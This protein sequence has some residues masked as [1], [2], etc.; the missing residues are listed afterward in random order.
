[1]DILM[2]GHSGSGKTTFMAGLYSRMKNGAAGFTIDS[3]YSE[4]RRNTSNY[5]YDNFLQQERDLDKIAENLHRG[6]YPPATMIKQGYYF[7]LV[8]NGHSIPFNWYDYRGGI[9]MER[10]TSSAD[11]SDIINKIKYA[12]ALVVFIDG[13]TLMENMNA[14]IRQYRRLITYINNALANISR[15]ENEYFP[16]S[17]VITKGDLHDWDDMIQSDGFNYFNENLFNPI[18]QSKD[19]IGM[20]TITEINSINIYNVHFPLL[21]SVLYGMPTYARSQIQKFKREMNN[22]GFF[23]RA[24][25]FFTDERKN[26][27]LRSW[28]AMEANWDRLKDTITDAQNKSIIFTF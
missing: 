24:I 17:F 4:Y 10:S 11:A 28:N 2:I 14:A 16:I 5:S 22:L 3:N 15:P 27:F 1:M 26:R 13:D 21:F 8:C 19:V 23:G 6:I 25:E 7:N 18:R 20:W 9:L 12:D